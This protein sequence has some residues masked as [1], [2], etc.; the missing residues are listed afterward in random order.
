[1]HIGLRNP[2]HP[3]FMNG[4]KLGTTEEEKDV[5]VYVDPTL[6]PSNHCK[7]V[8]EKA[9]AILNQ[10]TKNFHYRDKHTFLRLYKQYMRPHLE[11]ASPAWSSWPAGYIEVLEKV[12]EKAL[13]MNTGPKE[14]HMRRCKEVGMSS[15]QERWK[16]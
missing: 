12:Q 10:I 11:F 15:L 7:K 16:V 2:R 1:M 4:V 14:T 8:V 5:G 3:Y 13:R 9:R 6:K